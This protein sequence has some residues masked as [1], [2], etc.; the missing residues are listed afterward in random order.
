MIRW[1]RR[2]GLISAILVVVLSITGIMLAHSRDMGLDRATTDADWLLSLYGMQPDQDP[3]GVKAGPG[4]VVLVDGALYFFTDDGELV[5]ALSP[6]VA[7]SVEALGQVNGLAALRTPEGIFLSDDA[8]SIWS[9]A[10][11]V[12]GW[13][14]AA[15]VPD[16]VNEAAL[17]AYRGEGLAMERVLLDLHTGRLFG[18]VGVWV[19]DIAAIMFLI[20]AGTGI[21]IW[22]RNK[23]R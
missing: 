14:D 7:S 17:K 1:H 9:R 20:L 22:M 16:A 10:D 23:S 11:E 13:V 21:V 5:E 6:G 15:D 18:N 4:W 8:V 12:A 2:L 3:Q 19:M